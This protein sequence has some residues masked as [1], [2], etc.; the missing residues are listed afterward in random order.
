MC[1]PGLSDSAKQDTP[2][3]L[4]LSQNVAYFVFTVTGSSQRWNTFK[5]YCA[6]VSVFVRG[7]PQK[8]VAEPMKPVRIHLDA[9]SH[10]PMSFRQNP[11][12][13]LEQRRSL[14]Q[15]QE[16]LSRSTQGSPLEN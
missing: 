2:Q 12:S 8:E 5:R 10:L 1:N 11:S 13:T 15:Q 3:G 7:H 16:S 4:W 9:S 14:S 6:C